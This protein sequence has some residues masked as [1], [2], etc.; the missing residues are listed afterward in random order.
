MKNKS[1]RKILVNSNAPN[2]S[3]LTTAKR[4]NYIAQILGTLDQRLHNLE[5]GNSFTSSVEIY[6]ND[7]REIFLSAQPV[8]SDDEEELAEAVKYAFDAAD[9]I[10]EE[11][12][13]RM[14]ARLEEA[15]RKQEEEK[16]KAASEQKEAEGTDENVKEE[17]EDGQAGAPPGES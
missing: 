12:S 5:M 13:K 7:V 4:L 8:E 9:M 17:A 2:Q 11:F 3:E 6:R 16:A 14:K 10:E 1:H 15:R